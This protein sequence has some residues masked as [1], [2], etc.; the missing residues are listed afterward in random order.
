[1]E[2]A[3]GYHGMIQEFQ[4]TRYVK[5]FQ[6]LCIVTDFK[7]KKQGVATVTFSKFVNKKDN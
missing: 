1:M 3:G 7:N 2:T 4:D 6:A 5:E